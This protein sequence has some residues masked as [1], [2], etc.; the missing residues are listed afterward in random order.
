MEFINV[1]NKAV[2]SRMPFLKRKIKDTFG[3][4]GVSLYSLLYNEELLF[5]I[6]CTGNGLLI[7]SNGETIKFKKGMTGALTEIEKS[8]Y[9]IK[10]KIEY[11]LGD[12]LNIATDVSVVDK[13][14]NEAGICIL[15]SSVD[16]IYGDR[17]C[18][19]QYNKEKDMS[20]EI[21]YD[22]MSGNELIYPGLLNGIESVNIYREVSKKGISCKPG[23]VPSRM[24]MFYR[25]DIDNNTLNY[26]FVSFN[27]HGVFNTLL[28]SAY[29]LYD[30]AGYI[31]RFCKLGFMNFNHQLVELPWP[32][33][34][35]ATE[36]EILK[37]VTDNGFMVDIPDELIKTFNN[38]DDDIILLQEFLGN[39]DIHKKDRKYIRLKK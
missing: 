9:I 15:P 3:D 8:K 22:Y 29:N 11:G 30:N 27:E 17:V 1:S 16:S 34:K 13:Y 5:I 37:W 6:M 2:T 26:S 32:F 20:C 38:Q 12:D 33:G 10:P 19:T 24:Q 39:L 31:T 23:I 4:K 18:F 7:K 21:S 35:Y 14:G 25:N 28:H 36:E